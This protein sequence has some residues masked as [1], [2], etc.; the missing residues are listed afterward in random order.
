MAESREI[1][2]EANPG[3]RCEGLVGVRLPVV[4]PVLYP[5]GARVLRRIIVRMARSRRRTDVDGQS[6]E[7]AS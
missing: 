2:Q 4:P 1:E 3:T 5:Q 7:K 6:E